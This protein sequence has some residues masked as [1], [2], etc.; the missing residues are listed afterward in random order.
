MHPPTN[1]RRP[2]LLLKR[3]S[4]NFAKIA[5]LVPARTD[6]QLDRSF[7]RGTFGRGALSAC[8]GWRS[9]KLTYCEN[10]SVGRAP[11]C[12]GGGR[13][14]ESRF[15]LAS[16]PFSD[17]IWLRTELLKITNADVVELVDTPDLKSCALLGVRVQVPPSVRKPC[18]NG[19]G[20]FVE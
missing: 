10:S 9:L 12:Q 19:Q 11:P 2:A 18:S 3:R 16:T 13:G 6:G 15:S 8:G 20:F 7:W 14:F 5:Q 1:K 17:R 4:L